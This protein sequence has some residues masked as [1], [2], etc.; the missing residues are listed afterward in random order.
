MPD[1]ELRSLLP[2]TK[3][4]IKWKLEQFHPSVYLGRENIMMKDDLT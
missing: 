2:N 3:T 1:Y 4:E